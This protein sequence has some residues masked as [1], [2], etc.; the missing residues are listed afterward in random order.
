MAALA[1]KGGDAAFGKA[2]ELVEANFAV[3]ENE[4]AKVVDGR[5][6]PLTLGPASKSVDKIS[7]LVEEMH[8]EKGKLRDALLEV[9]KVHGAVLFRGFDAPGAEQF[10]EFVR[11][12][13]LENMPYVGGAAVRRNIVGDYVFTANESPPSGECSL[14]VVVT[15]VATG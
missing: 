4:T 13:K 8:S 11:G 2:M 10:G 14:V 1:G 6:F 15:F 3:L 5:A 7:T 12:M 9:A